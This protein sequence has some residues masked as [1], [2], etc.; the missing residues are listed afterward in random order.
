[1]A[2]AAEMPANVHAEKA[3]TVTQYGITWTFDK[4]YEVGKFVNG[5]WWV[6][7]PAKV[8]KVDPAPGA[9]TEPPGASE[10]KS[11]YGAVAMVPDTR[12]RNGSM[13]LD[14]ELTA[15][16]GY[17][18]RL[19]NYNPALTVAFPLDLEANRSLISTI[20]NETFPMPCLLTDLM[21]SS[22]KNG[23]PAL[24]T[25]AVLT[26]LSSVPPAD[27]FRPPYAGTSKPIYELKNLQW[28]S[29]PSIE[30]AGPVPSFAQ[31][32]RYYQRPWLDHTQNWVFQYMGPCENQPNYGR[33]FSRV[34]SITSLML[35]LNVPQAE[36]E[37]LMIG[38]IQHGID[39]AG[40]TKAGRVW[41]ADG[42]HWN[43]RKWPIL[44][45]GLMLG[46]AE[47]Q[48]LATKG[49]FSENRQTY[50]GKGWYGQTVLYQIVLHTSAQPP[51]EEKRPETWDAKQKQQEGY[52]ITISPSWP[53]T[54]LAVL[55][56][57]AKGA[58]NHDA[59]FDYC[60]RW[61]RPGSPTMEQRGGVPRNPKEGMAMDPFVDA[62]WKAYR[63]KVPA[64][65]DGAENLKWTWN[66][67][68]KSGRY[69]P[70]AR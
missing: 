10:V 70:N 6:A 34:G 65:P 55:L 62:M 50:Y 25:A 54:A 56:M 7:G 22:E 68:L 59:F 32:A 49:D 47:M 33:E 28:K 35:M 11:R 52:R 17:D 14:K 19:K 46:D 24:R 40:L 61:M 51:Y 38:F 16:Q 8:I 21:W 4:P 57:K 3:Q 27:A 37:K 39:L 67:D 69:E 1:M 43:G 29:L 66:A 26:C 63:D 30:P 9:G 45:A 58:W 12:M 36:K 18:S 31:F 64:Q 23:S 20:S 13:V 48:Q 60:D 5:D 41:T 42:G 44:F 53:G 15:S 2:L